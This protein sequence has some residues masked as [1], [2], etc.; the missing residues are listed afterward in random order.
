MSA[1]FQAI[2][3]LLQSAGV[4]TIWM[5]A[6]YLV[7][8]IM[9][10]LLAITGIVLVLRTLGLVIRSIVDKCCRAQNVCKHIRDAMGLGCSGPIDSTEFTKI[11][12]ALEKMIIKYKER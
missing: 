9:E 11:E 4:G 7:Y 6:G 2:I 1:E 5:F 12:S 3:E 10:T 8:Q